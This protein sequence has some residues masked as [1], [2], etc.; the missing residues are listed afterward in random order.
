MLY[1]VITM[2]D[3]VTKGTGA[4]VNF[5][6]MA[7]AGKTGT[8][9]DYKDVWFSGYTPYYTATTWAGYDNNTSLSGSGEKNLA[10]TLWRSRITSYNVCYT[11]LLRQSHILHSLFFS[12]T[13]EYILF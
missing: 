5:G 12:S 3:V 2:V 8:T 9:T 13:A 11:K 10:K 4:S 6:N 7:M 1:E